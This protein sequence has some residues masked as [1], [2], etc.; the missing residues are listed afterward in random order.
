M[1]NLV[2]KN[3][4][5][6]VLSNMEK[7]KQGFIEVDKK[8][9]HWKEGYSAHSLGKFFTE[10]N[11]QQWLD[12][13][14]KQILGSS[15]L[16]ADAEIEHPSKL[17]SYKG[18][19][20]M[21]DLAI[22]GKTQEGK[23]VFIGIEAKVLETFD[24]T[25]QDA[26]IEAEAIQK[27]KPKSNKLNRI[28]DVLNTLFPGKSPSSLNMLR[29]QLTHYFVGGLKEAPSLSISNTPYSEN[30]A[31][32]DIVVLP[33]LVFKTKRYEENPGV[34]EDNK[35]DYLDFCKA[36]EGMEHIP[37]KSYEN[38]FHKRILNQDLYTLYEAVPLP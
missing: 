10:C 2:I 18:G 4:S 29:Y 16:Y 6:R 3:S 22:W 1:S 14:L 23:S 19:Q 12:N 7:W 33:V 26:I 8:P 13:M 27:K 24:E 36:V 34:A 30:R 35:N 31:V 38:A 9:M 15:V 28:Y 21:Q 17:D 37:N 32:A 20:R 5:G 11:G 25:I